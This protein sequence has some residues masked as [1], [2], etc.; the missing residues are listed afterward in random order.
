MI[1]LNS[2]GPH[3]SKTEGEELIENIIK[4]IYSF[5][6]R[7]DTFKK[8]EKE[9]ANTKVFLTD[10]ETDTQTFL[11]NQTQNISVLTYVVGESSITAKL[12]Q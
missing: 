5:E 7:Y 3:L 1:M 11:K 6:K 8:R 9:S 12:I 2:F 10:K 4:E